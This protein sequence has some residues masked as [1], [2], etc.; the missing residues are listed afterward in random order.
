M[1]AKIKAEEAQA[2]AK[3]A[4][5]EYLAT[6]DCRYWPDAEAVLV[7]RLRADRNECVRYAAARAMG[8]G[9]CC[10]KKTIAALKLVV[11]CADTDGNPVERSERVKAAVV[12]RAE[13]LRGPLRPPPPEPGERPTE[14]PPRVPR[15]P[16]GRTPRGRRSGTPWTTRPTPS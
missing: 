6:V 14:P 11:E 9:C 12:V 13:P 1:A 8:T 15:R 7:E 2:K 4:A 5:I 10:T 16:P 3:I